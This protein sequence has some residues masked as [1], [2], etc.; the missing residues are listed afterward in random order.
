MSRA[1]KSCGAGQRSRRAKRA[2]SCWDRL[3]PAGSRPLVL[4]PAA[5]LWADLHHL[6]AGLSSV[7]MAHQ[8]SQDLMHAQGAHA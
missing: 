8:S 5:A 1:G 4:A 7:D 6:P 2:R 3:A